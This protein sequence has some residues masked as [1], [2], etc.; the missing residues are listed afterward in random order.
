MGHEVPA[1]SVISSSSVKN[2]DVRYDEDNRFQPH[3]DEH[4]K[5]MLARV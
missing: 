5:E 2:G 1:D 3:S 4:S